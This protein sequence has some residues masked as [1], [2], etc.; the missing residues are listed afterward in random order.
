MIASISMRTFGT[1]FP[2][3][4]KNI[5]MVKA[6]IFISG[7]FILSHLLFWLIF[8]L[9]YIS[10]KKATLKKPCILAIAGSFAVSV[11]Y[12]KK[13]P[14]VFGMNIH[15]PPV[16]LNPYYD[17]LVPL[18]SSALH[19]IFFVAFKRVLEVDEKA[20]LRKPLVSIITGISIYIFLHLIVLINFLATNKFEWIEHMPK[21]VAVSTLPFII[22][23]VFLILFFY[24]KFYHF[25]DT[26][27]KMKTGRK[28]P[29]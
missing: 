23:A 29:S 9:E 21:V 4:F 8:Y 5:P 16:L 25:L 22:A 3:I 12:M 28:G 19:L 27:D 7:V 1:V 17:A 20:R 11:I 13:L 15:F 10:K 18:M 2:Q 24:Y 14:Y 26:S 6:A